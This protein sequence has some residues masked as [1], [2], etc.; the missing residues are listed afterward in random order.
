MHSNRELS[1]V[2]YLTL[3]AFLF[4]AACSSTPSTERADEEA[5]EAT[6]ACLADPRLAESWGECNVKATIFSHMEQI[7]S[8]QQ[9]F[10]KGPAPKEALIL[11]I[12]LRPNGKVRDVFAEEGGPRNRAL[13]ACLSQEI[14][15]LRFAAPPKGV[16]PV[17]YFPFQQQ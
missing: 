5:A 12:R 8:C 4:L 3:F 16:K 13:E 17:I 14:S 9:R 11:K 6:D 15:K 2:R 7:R 1:T 10:A